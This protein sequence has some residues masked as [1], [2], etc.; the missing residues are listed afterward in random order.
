MNKRLAV[1]LI[2]VSGAV[3]AVHWP[4][5]RAGALSVDDEGV[6]VNNDLVRNPGWSSVRRFVTDWY[7]GSAAPGYPQPVTMISLMLD[8][9]L[10]GRPD[11]LGPF[12]RTSLVLHVANTCLV[13]AL[14]YML[15]LAERKKG[16]F[17]NAGLERAFPSGASDGKG[18]TPNTD[19]RFPCASSA[20]MAGL[21]FGVHPLA[22]E[23]VVWIAQRKALMAAFFSLACLVLYVGYVRRP[24][25]VRYGGCLA[26]FVLALGSKPTSIPLPLVLMLLDLWP[27]RRLTKIINF[28]LLE[29]VPFFVLATLAGWI[30]YQTNASPG[31]PAFDVGHTVLRVVH[32]I[33][34]YIGKMLWPVNLSNCYAAPDSFA[35]SNGS[36]MSGLL[37]SSGLLAAALISLRR[38][39]A[40]AVGLAIWFVLLFPTMGAVSFGTLYVFDNYL[41]LPAVGLL[42]IL[43][44]AFGRLQARRP[45]Q[46]P[47]VW[48]VVCGVAA[49]EIYVTRQYFH[50]WADTET[51]ARYLVAVSPGSGVSHHQLGV[52]LMGRG[53]VDKAAEQ[54]REAVRLKPDY[55]PAHVNIGTIELQHERVEQAAERFTKAVTLVPRSAV[56]HCNLGVAL[57][58]LDRTD[59]AIG[60]FEEAVR[61][62]PDFA[63][64]R[65]NLGNLL[66][67]AGRLDEAVLHLERAVQLKP[68]YVEA[69]YNLGVALARQ[70][71]IS[72]AVAA[73]EEALRLRPDWPLA[74]NALA[75]LAASRPSSARPGRE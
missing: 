71:R 20:A 48:A 31:A 67:H 61:L 68:E 36:V 66:T 22:V 43:A 38:T 30:T 64:A 5:L 58:R 50:A 19:V 37:V 44:W 52:V 69:H 34:F 6:L 29:K 49:M 70:G 47:V 53:E 46:V 33:G 8:C 75:R 63:E 56:A 55:A 13:V 24:G 3:V 4:A 54:F 16:A 60:R 59:E 26:A 18:S 45:G 74:H 65:N 73:Y 62:N 39:R 12:H 35:L 15:L 21:L 14:L 25:A 7:D 72:E 9:Q 23:P 1:L 2:V 51:H 42:L 40:V 57:A 17:V 41:Y 27:L 11:N 32:Q 28:R 10:G